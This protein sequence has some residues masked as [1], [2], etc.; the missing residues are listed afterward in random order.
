MHHGNTNQ[1][2]A[3][4][5]PMQNYKHSWTNEEMLKGGG[6]TKVTVQVQDGDESDGEGDMQPCYW[7]ETLTDPE[8]VHNTFVI[9]AKDW[10]HQSGKTPWAAGLGQQLLRDRVYG[11]IIRKRLLE[12]TFS[13]RGQT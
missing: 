11:E 9:F 13:Q 1:R 2:K 5:G 8:K 4:V 10:F 3:N 7:H 6:I 12:G